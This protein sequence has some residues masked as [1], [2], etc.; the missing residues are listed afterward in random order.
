MA[1][2]WGAGGGAARAGASGDEAHCDCGR[3]IWGNADG[4]VSGKRAGKKSGGARDADQRHQRASVYADVGGSGGGQPGAEPHQPA[5]AREGLR[6]TQFIRART[7]GID[8]E[9]KCVEIE[10]PTSTPG[11]FERRN[12][13]YDHVVL[14]LGAASNYLGMG[15]VEKL[16]STSRA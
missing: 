2:M 8:L 5:V 15:N 14:A 4:A 1:K 6:R 3:R 10:E 9:K 12:I 7:T 16:R 13:E 11:K